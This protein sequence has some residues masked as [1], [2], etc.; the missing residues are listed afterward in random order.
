LVELDGYVKRAQALDRL[1]QYYLLALYRQVVGSE[2]L[3]DVLR[4]D[5]SV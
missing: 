1:F 2:K 3:G 5:R 4:C